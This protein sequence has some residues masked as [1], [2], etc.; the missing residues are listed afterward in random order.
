MADLTV[1]SGGNVNLFSPGGK[2]VAVLLWP[3]PKTEVERVELEMTWCSHRSN[4]IISNAK[5]KLIKGLEEDCRVS[6]TK[7]E[8]VELDCC[9]KHWGMTSENQCTYSERERNAYDY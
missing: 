3:W 1:G 4:F 9:Y 5:N 6:S 8:V 2:F 7:P